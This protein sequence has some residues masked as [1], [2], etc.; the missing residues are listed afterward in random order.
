MLSGGSI[1][2]T[3]VNHTATIHQQRDWAHM[4]TSKQTIVKIEPPL[5]L[6]RPGNPCVK[7]D[8]PAHQPK[9]PSKHARRAPARHTLVQ[10]SGFA[11]QLTVNLPQ[12]LSELTKLFQE[13]PTF[14]GVR[15]CQL[16]NSVLYI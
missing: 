13:C 16:C 4:A 5:I 8:N 15:G 2:A 12:N 14:Q 6:G 3:R 9:S 7:I 11:F 10:V 1:M